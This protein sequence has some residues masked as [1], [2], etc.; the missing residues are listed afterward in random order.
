MRAADSEGGAAG[1]QGELSQKRKDKLN[2][3]RSHREQ[4][5]NGLKIVLALLVNHVLPVW[6][7]PQRQSRL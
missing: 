7:T 3:Q 1:L 5:S 2:P 4:T 6:K